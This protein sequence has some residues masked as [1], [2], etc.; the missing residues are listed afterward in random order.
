MT[1]QDHRVARAGCLDEDLPGSAVRRGVRLHRCG[2]GDGA[3]ADERRRQRLPAG[4]TRILVVPVLHGRLTEPPAE[5]HAT[6]IELAREVDETDAAVL[7]L[8]PERI[9]LGLKRIDLA[10]DLL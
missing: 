10:F 1:E 9:Q 3:S 7:E 8:N 6:T 4:E 2:E 5:E